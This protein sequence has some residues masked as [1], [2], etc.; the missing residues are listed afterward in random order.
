MKWVMEWNREGPP[1]EDWIKA[2]ESV[3]MD[4]QNRNINADGPTML[5]QA[6]LARWA[7]TSLLLLAPAFSKPT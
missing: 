2:R 3:H 7:D 5:N 4:V 6:E 1:L